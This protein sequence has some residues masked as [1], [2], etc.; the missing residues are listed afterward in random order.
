MI[1]ILITSFDPNASEK[2]GRKA[3]FISA[4]AMPRP[5][6]EESDML[7]KKC[8]GAKRPWVGLQESSALWSRSTLFGAVTDHSLVGSCKNFSQLGTLDSSHAKI[9]GQSRQKSRVKSE[10]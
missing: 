5:G 1:M 7:W 9:P 4:W 8:R 3:K 2:I 6:S 10:G